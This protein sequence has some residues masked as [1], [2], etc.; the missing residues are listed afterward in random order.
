METS[1]TLHFCRVGKNLEREL[2]LHT[3]HHLQTQNLQHHLLVHQEDHL[4]PKWVE[5]HSLQVTECHG[6]YQKIQW[7]VILLKK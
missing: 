7:Q 3:D 5:G 4:H 6:H 1:F 2:N